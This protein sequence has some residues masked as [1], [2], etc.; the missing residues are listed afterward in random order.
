MGCLL[1][2]QPLI[3]ILPQFQQWCVQSHI[4]LDRIIRHS[5]VYG[6]IIYEGVYTVVTIK[7]FTHVRYNTK[8]SKHWD[9]QH[10]IDAILKPCK[11]LIPK[12]PLFKV[13]NKLISQKT[14]QCI[15]TW[16]ARFTGLVWDLNFI[17]L[18]PRRHSWA[19][20]WSHLRPSWGRKN[21]DGSNIG[22]M[23]LACNIKS[24]WSPIVDQSYRS[25]ALWGG[26]DEL[27]V[28]Q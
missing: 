21:Q 27:G 6:I 26:C 9:F 7:Q 1:W 8:L 19:P 12:L 24:L 15:K 13:T 2:V 18:T 14:L 3:D 4:M 22:F 10:V 16:I 28:C 5:T 23:D 20:S 11:S 17:L 25:W